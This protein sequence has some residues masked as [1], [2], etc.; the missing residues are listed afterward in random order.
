M[1]KIGILAYGSLIRDPGVEIQPLVAERIATQSP[2]PVEYARLSRS[3][4]G[5]PTVVPHTSGKPVPA[6]ILVLKNSVSLAEAKNLLWRRETRNEGTGK[7]YVEGSSPGSV[8][9][10]DSPGLQGIGHV[11]FTDFPPSGKVAHPDAHSLAKAAVASVAKA[12]IGKDGISYLMQLVES[13]VETALTGEYCAEV[14]LLTGAKTLLQAAGW[15]QANRVVKQL[16]RKLCERAGPRVDA[17]GYFPTVEDNLIPG[18]HLRQFDQDLRAGAG[19]ELDQKFRAVRSSTALVVNAF[20]P[21]K[22]QPGALL[23]L[24]RLGV[25][26]L[27]FEKSLPTGLRG[28]APH[29]DVWLERENGVVGIESKLLEYFAPK[30]AKFA[31]SY[32]R[33]ALP[34][35]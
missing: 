6:T 31:G 13:G 12:P 25:G 15:L 30:K 26:G 1:T 19:H 2:F 22:E 9:V 33:A 8:L 23:L 27:R 32:E 20:A 7:L 34:R 35:A 10:K 17:R 3:R 28:T 14:L 24:E 5:G 11:L 16:E 29:L 18:V 4:G 21:F